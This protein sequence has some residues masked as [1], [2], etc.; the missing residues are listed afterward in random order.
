MSIYDDNCP[1]KKSQNLY[2]RGKPEKIIYIKNNYDSY[3]LVHVPR[4]YNLNNDTYK[5]SQNQQ[6]F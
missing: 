2:Y 3:S 1:Q 4:D 5:N 6:Y